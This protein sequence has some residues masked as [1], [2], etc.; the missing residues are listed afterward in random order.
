MVIVDE[1]IDLAAIALPDN[2]T[3]GSLRF[4]DETPTE[5]RDVFTA[6]YPGLGDNPSP[7][8]C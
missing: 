6:G 8:T 5:G 3:V 1:D 2:I 4:A 7:S